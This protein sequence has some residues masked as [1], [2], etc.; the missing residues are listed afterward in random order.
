MSLYLASACHEVAIANAVKNAAKDPLGA[1]SVAIEYSLIPYYRSR[2]EHTD[3]A[4]WH[5]AA[6]RKQ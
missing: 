6:A 4:K 5:A 3:T 1:V 2:L